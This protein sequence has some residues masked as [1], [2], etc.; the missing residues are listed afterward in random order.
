M[1][2]RNSGQAPFLISKKALSMVCRLAV[3]WYFYVVLLSVSSTKIVAPAFLE[4]EIDL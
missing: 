3:F 4:K 1:F 2:M